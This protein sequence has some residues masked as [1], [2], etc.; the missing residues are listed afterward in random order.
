MFP[1]EVFLGGTCIGFLFSTAIR[2]SCSRGSGM[3]HFIAM[4]FGDL[5]PHLILLANCMLPLHSQPES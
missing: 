5:A 4:A 1:L 2:L 3:L